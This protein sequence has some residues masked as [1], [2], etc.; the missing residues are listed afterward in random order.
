MSALGARLQEQTVTKTCLQASFQTD[1]LTICSLYE[2]KHSKGIN[3]NKS[4]DFCKIKINTSWKNAKK[5]RKWFVR[6]SCHNRFDRRLTVGWPSGLHTYWRVFGGIQHVMVKK[7]GQRL[8]TI[9][10]N[11]RRTKLVNDYQPLPTIAEGQSWSTII[12]N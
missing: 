3:P 11:W 5:I 4:S 7:R 9:T 1:L 10:N 6:W 8:S 2:L 12:N